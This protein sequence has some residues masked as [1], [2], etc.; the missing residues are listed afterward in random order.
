MRSF[1]TAAAVCLA[2][3]AVA[4]ADDQYDIKVYPCPRAGGGVV[5]DGRLTEAAWER[6]PLVSGFTRY[7]KPEL[8]EPQTSLRVMYDESN[9]YFGVVCDEPRM[10]KLTAV[11]HA[12]D[13]AEVFHGEA[14]EIFV[15]PDH[16]QRTYY[17]F[18]INAAASIY[19]S[20]LTD[21][22]WSANVR[23]ATVLG[24]DAWSL[25]VA[26]PWADLG[27]APENGAVFSF[28]VCRDRLLGPDKQWS[29]WSQTAANFHDPLRFAPAVL[30]PDAKRLGELE[31]EYRRG[32]R[33]G[34]IL[35][36]GPPSL[37]EAA[38]RGLG[39]RALAAAD[40]LLDGMQETL[41]QEREAGARDEMAGRINSYRQELAG[42]ATG[43]EGGKPLGADAWKQMTFRLAEMRIELDRLVWE[44]RLS[45]LISSI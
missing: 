2:L 28:N 13:S 9:L 21:P 44:A 4:H 42:F 31:G 10:D 5:V 29:N 35:L 25:E 22:A 3:G 33:D 30:S 16:D 15:D 40:K 14:I 37:T 17:Q 26:I 45:A 19:D 1:L 23:A 6:A 8:V 38:Y 11:G 39:L 36:C 34:A 7:D 27:V 32:G 18:G 43:I 41:A 12:R 24:D 20:R